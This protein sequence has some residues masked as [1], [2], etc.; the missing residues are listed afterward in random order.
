MEVAQAE[1]RLR[2]RQEGLRGDDRERVR[3][4]RAQGQG[5]PGVLDRLRAQAEVH[6]D[7][8]GPGEHERAGPV[9][10]VAAVGD[11]RRRA[12]RPTVH[13]RRPVAALDRD[14]RSLAQ[15][16]R[17]RAGRCPP[18]RR[19]PGPRRTG[20]PRG[21]GRRRAGRR[22]PRCA[23]SSRAAGS[24]GTALPTPS[25]ASSRIC[26]VPWRASIASRYASVASTVLPSDRVPGPGAA[27]AIADHRSARAG[28]PTSAKMS[29]ACAAIAG[30]ALTSFASSSHDIQLVDRVDAAVDPGLLRPV[31]DEPGELGDVAAAVRVLDRLVRDAGVG[32]PAGRAAVQ[33]RHQRGLLAV[34]LGASR[35]RRRGWHRKRS[36]SR[37]TGWITPCAARCSSAAPEERAR[38]TASH[39]GPDSSSRIAHRTRSAVSRAPSPASTSVRRYSRMN[40]SSP[41]NVRG[42]VRR[43]ATPSRRAT[44]RPASPR[45]GPAARPSRSARG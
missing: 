30:K 19:P 32:V 10:A 38:S 16:H 37:S 45:C 27:F 22:A 23:A 36:P 9:R 44:P 33:L 28:S 40:T 21:R 4:Q 15:D 35:S 7:A 18:P 8:G 24:P 6:G 17:R 1:R 29:A 11:D 42:A 5:A 39:S 14:R 26:S 3:E 20:R 41:V 2:R 31:E 25:R 12:A 13:R 34:Q 43:A